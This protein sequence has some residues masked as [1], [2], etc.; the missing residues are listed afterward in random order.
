MF[1]SYR[2]SKLVSNSS[3]QKCA[4]QF[5]TDLLEVPVDAETQKHQPKTLAIVLSVCEGQTF[6]M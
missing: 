3:Y 2:S 5:R 6:K 4:A 1:F